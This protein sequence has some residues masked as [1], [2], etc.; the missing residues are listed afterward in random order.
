MSRI[1]PTNGERSLSYLV[2]EKNVNV[3]YQGLRDL[4][5]HFEGFYHVANKEVCR[6]H[7]PI[8]KKVS[9][10]EVEWT[11]FLS[12]LTFPFQVQIT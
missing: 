12:E 2:C 10:A 9:L 5:S 4:V 11:S 1:H 3:E 8:E 6:K 7:D